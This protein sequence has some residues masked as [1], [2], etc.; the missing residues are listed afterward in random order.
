M[1]SRPAPYRAAGQQQIHLDGRHMRRAGEAHAHGHGA[2]CHRLQRAKDKAWARG[3][4]KEHPMQRTRTYEAE[5]SAGFADAGLQV[6]RT[7]MLVRVSLLSL[8]LSLYECMLCY[9]TR[10]STSGSLGPGED[11]WTRG[12]GSPHGSA[13]RVALHVHR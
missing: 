11:D 12:F 2:T 6:V 9:R 1:R 4:T 5:S 13:R 7:C 3:L 8:S 10:R